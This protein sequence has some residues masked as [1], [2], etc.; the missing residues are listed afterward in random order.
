[1]GNIDEKWG[2]LKYIEPTNIFNESNS[3]WGED[4]SFPY[5]DYCMS[6][7]LTVHI[8]NRY[9]CGWPKKNGKK[10]ELRYSSGNGSISFLGGSKISD[11]LP[12]SYLTTNFTDI[13][14]TNPG[15]NTSECLGIESI[16]IA[17]NS[18]T[19]PEVTI[20][21]IDVRGATVMQPSES[22]YYNKKDL[23]ISKELYKAL[24]TFPYPM[25]ELKVKGFYGKGVTYKLAVNKT[26]IELDSQSGNFVITVSF[27]GFMYGIYTDLPMT[28]ISCA[29]YV[30]GGAEYWETKVN[31]GTFMFK[32][33]AGQPSYPMIK[34][35]E[36]RKKAAEVAKNED[37]TSAASRG[38]ETLNRL[39]D[40]I[41]ALR[42][43][44]DLCPLKDFV[45]LN[46]KIPYLYKLML[47]DNEIGSFQNSIS[48]FEEELKNYKLSYNI[49]YTQKFVNLLNLKESNFDS[50]N[51]GYII[52]DGKIHYFNNNIAT[53]YD[54]VETYVLSKKDSK[55]KY[56]CFVEKSNFDYNEFNN[57]INKEITL[58]KQQKEKED[59]NYKTKEMEIIEKV[60]GFRP[61]IRNIYELIFAHMETFLHC[62]YEQTGEIGKQIDSNSKFRRKSTYGIVPGDT[63]T[64]DATSNTDGTLS[65][66]NF[67][68][69]Y[70]AFYKNTTTGVM[71]KDSGFTTSRKEM[72]WPEEFDNYTSNLE[73]VKFVKSII[74][75][76][77]LYYN[78]NKEIDN[79]ISGY[80]SN[81]ITTPTTSIG[82]FIPL[83]TYDF[84]YK[85]LIG[86]PY[87]IVKN[88]IEN[89]EDIEGD[90]LGLFALRAFYYNS[91]NIDENDARSFGVLEALNF[92]KAIGNSISK[93]FF[94]FIKIYADGR[95]TNNENSNFIN[96]ITGNSNSK[97]ADVWKYSEFSRLFKN[98]GN[99]IEYSLHDLY[100]NTTSE[101]MLP[102]GEFNFVNIK[103]AYVS[104]KS[105]YDNIKY[106]STTI[107]NEN[108]TVLTPSFK[109]FDDKDYVN[110]ILDAVEKEIEESTQY[111]KLQKGENNSTDYNHYGR[112]V[113]KNRVLLHYQQDSESDED[114]VLKYKDIVRDIK[115]EKQIGGNKL[116][117]MILNDKASLLSN[118]Y[119][120]TTP[121][122]N[123]EGK[124]YN[125]YGDESLS[126]ESG[127]TKAF[128]FLKYIPVQNNGLVKKSSNGLI[129]KISL[130]KE[131]AQYWAVEK[132]LIT[133]DEC[134]YPKY[135]T[136]SRI[137]VLKEFFIEWSNSEQ[138][139]RIDENLKNKELYSNKQFFVLNLSLKTPDATN[140]QNDLKDLYF[141]VYTTFDLYNNIKSKNIISTSRKSMSDAFGGFIDELNK[142]YGDTL[143]KIDD[144]GTYET[145][146]RER[147][148]R[149]QVA[150][151]FK[152]N[153][154]YLSTYITLKSLYDK[155]LCA[156]PDNPDEVWSLDKVG[157]EKNLKSDFNNF[158]YTDSFYHDIGYIFP[159]NITKVATWLDSCL[160]TL[161]TES[162]E[163]IMG[164][165]GKSVYNF[166]SELAQDSGGML[167][168]IPQRFGSYDQKSV[169]DAFTAYPLYG[170]WDT[171]ESSFVFMYTYKP[172]EHLGDMD[173][174]GEDMNG[175]SREGD[176]LNLTDKE[177]MGLITGD[178]GYTIPAFGVTHAKQN[179]SMFNNIRLN[180]ADAGVTE[181][182]LAA[183]FNIASKAS[184]GP[185][186]TMLYG[187]DLYR[188]YSQYSYKCS[189]EMMGNA[190][191]MPLMYFQLNN[192]P[193]WKGGYQILKVNHEISA[194]D[195]KTTFEGVRINRNSIPFAGSVAITIKDT[196][197]HDAEDNREILGNNK[198]NTSN[199]TMTDI[200]GNSN[201]I[202][203]TIDFNENNVSETKPIICITPAHGPK[204]QKR[205]EWEW[206]SKLVD[207]MKEK[208]S[209]ETYK[210]GT[211]YN[212]QRCNKNGQNSSA[213]GYSMRETKNII[214][215]FGSKKVVSIVPHW[216][217]G[218]GQRYEI[219]TNYEGKTRDDSAILAQKMKEAVDNFL[220]KKDEL[221]ICGQSGCSCAFN[222]IVEIKSLPSTNT[223][224]APQLDCAC[225]LTEN[226]FADY[227]CENNK[228]GVNK[229]K[230]GKL[231]G[232]LCQWL[233]DDGL[234]E[235]I[236][237]MHVNAIKSYIDS[238]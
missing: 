237:Q 16:S 69:P 176:G 171:D 233:F 2:R 57:H 218:G 75:G 98:V 82:G 13:S 14:M 230:S 47:N 136:P 25:F 46:D 70:T 191:I 132:G 4:I 141:K 43:L 147:I 108:T 196:G 201:V 224:G 112:I 217:G 100:K 21:F 18:W 131:G 142:I 179:Q 121:L 120:I 54:D 62:F 89:N 203:E 197:E 24:F 178:D 140:L 10:R 88:K 156:P 110:N 1:M 212:V 23:G 172:S 139:K 182:G 223:D 106:I 228:S 175:Y 193:L 155:W 138:F 206:S 83:T 42:T 51:A 55:T 31:D 116:R 189:V 103:N 183:T 148:N 81:N 219:Y 93:K 9:S 167:L 195:F 164:Y 154:L 152:S 215:K 61:S 211:P 36:L 92:Y 114:T 115:T 125:F 151:P 29:P 97:G 160:P 68:P 181:A 27:I 225:I 22:T 102:I 169:K 41:A 200:K 165:H 208:L 163:S 67:L 186:E 232:L 52:N 143:D 20:K 184:E 126:N 188:V 135:C 222:N 76:G 104:S 161:S 180:T 63:D 234:I 128:L 80:N 50:F 66:T 150:N 95:K 79:I 214:N 159:V 12:E 229:W 157:K 91:I 34:I 174:K 137:K 64:E 56:L 39:D 38:R 123:L 236:A 204:T 213:A 205:L 3:G 220:A 226:W 60:L 227:D 149:E 85:D 78:K 210:D 77:E 58:L 129:L 87:S 105:L 199:N 177:Y 71:S 8:T 94:D 146:V 162:T 145:F 33:I 74:N 48:A 73:E 238:L 194:G 133:S 6:V 45:S 65:L 86:N 144:K 19:H 37:A 84:I 209:N 119:F 158:I 7:D 107:P 124:N 101:A 192:V 32:D 127:E 111:M 216:N 5:E 11:N 198:I 44:S 99:D 122:Q 207:K 28:F 130:L 202:I 235:R 17:Y 26:D 59:L 118:D 168:A 173:T 40:Q 49:D 170:D 185:R 53:S 187:Q 96:L 72:V 221:G 153:D 35:P 109:I 90:I 15:E 231:D 30:P 113:N 134:E 117:K 166:L 190:Q